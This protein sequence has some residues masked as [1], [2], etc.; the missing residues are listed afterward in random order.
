MLHL[1]FEC[2]NMLILCEWECL[3]AG[4]VAGFLV[5]YTLYSFTVRIKRNFNITDIYA[6]M[7]HY[8]MEM[9]TFLNRSQ[10]SEPSRHFN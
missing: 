9:L 5:S 10:K 7:S 2:I 8:Y 1:L 6:N 4:V 3:V